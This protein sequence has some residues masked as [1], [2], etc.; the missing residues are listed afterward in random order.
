MHISNEFH[1]STHSTGNSARWGCYAS[2]VGNNKA[3]LFTKE[4]DGL[5][6]S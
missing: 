1:T 2:R 6:T 5:A 3:S 4:R